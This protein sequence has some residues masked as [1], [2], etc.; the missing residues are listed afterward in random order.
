MSVMSKTFTLVVLRHGESQWNLENR[1]TGWVDVDLTPRGIEEAKAAG[2]LLRAKGYQFDQA[3]TS[4]LKRAIRTLWITIDS[5]DQM[6]LPVSKEWRLNERHYGALSGLNKAETAAKYGDAQVLTWRR[7][8]DVR[9]DAMTSEHPHWPAK[10]PRYAGIAPS[11]LPATECLKDTIERV[12]PVWESKIAPAV[13]SGQR[14]LISAHGN[15]IRALIKYLEDMSEADILALNIPTAQPLAITLD[16][17]LR[18]VDRQ[19]LADPAVIQA[20]LTAVANQGKAK[21]A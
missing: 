12:I 7:A 5:L 20:A 18:C 1:F 21:T 3:F 11:L 4:V 2:A 8:Y 19:Y 9:P 16:E 10:D 15:S 6:W 14:V 13:K 17:N